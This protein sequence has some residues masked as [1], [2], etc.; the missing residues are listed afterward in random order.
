MSFG[1]EAVELLNLFANGLLVGEGAKEEMK[2]N[3]R[4]VHDVAK[5]NNYDPLLQHNIP[6][7]QRIGR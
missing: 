3:K 5:R 7:E 6:R 1:S 2:N 4:I